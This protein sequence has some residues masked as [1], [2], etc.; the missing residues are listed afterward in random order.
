MRGPLPS[1]RFRLTGTQK[2]RLKRE[3]RCR[4]MPAR[5]VQRRRIVLL[6]AEGRDNTQIA[7]LVGCDRETVIRWR[8]RFA[9]GGVEALVEEPRSGRPR[10]ITSLERHEIVSMACRL[11][12]DFGIERSQWS[13]SSLRDTAMQLG[14]V[15]DISTTSVGNILNEVDLC[16]SKFR[17]WLY[18]KDPCFDERMRDIVQVYTVLV[19]QRGEVAV[20]IDEKTS[21]QALERLQPIAAP[22]RGYRGLIEGEYIR[23]GTTCLFAGFDVGTGKVLGW[24]NPT[25]KQPDFLAF[26]DKVA[27]AYPTGKVH[28]VLDN[29]NTHDCTETRDW[30]RRHNRRFDFHFT[31]TH[32]SWL[33]QVEIWFSLLQRE[34]LKNASFGAIDELTYALD[35]YISQ[36][37]EN[38][39]HPFDWTWK[40]YPLR[41]GSSGLLRRLKER[42]MKG[43]CTPDLSKPVNPV[44]GHDFV[45]Q[46]PWHEARYP[47]SCRPPPEFDCQT[48]LH[49]RATRAQA[50]YTS[51]SGA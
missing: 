24:C 11:P 46:T 50:G 10:R 28:L 43:S 2:R 47:S 25:R 4:T 42:I 21:I 36:W 14:R 18:S 35:N 20:C 39:A 6:A 38:R 12:K 51:L 7:R 41:R 16:P 30:N 40:G 31:P 26:L 15:K 32:A 44:E 45:G 23:H 33:N 27:D 1:D 48:P 13:I 17:M 5:Y 22:A 37:N 9:V 29:L 8:H 3:C 49:E 19:P 34:R